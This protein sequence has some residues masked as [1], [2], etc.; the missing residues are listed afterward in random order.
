MEVM[1][2][3]LDLHLRN[4]CFLEHPFSLLHLCFAFYL[5]T[6]CFR[7]WACLDSNQGPLPYQRSAT[8]CR[9]VLE[10]AKSLQIEIF[11]VRCFSQRFRIFAWVAARL[12]HIAHPHPAQ[13]RRQI[14]VERHRYEDGDA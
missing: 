8:L 1:W 6:V 14:V 2:E 5:Q 3:L 13:E 4:A 11:F 7:W 9:G 12:L 10:F